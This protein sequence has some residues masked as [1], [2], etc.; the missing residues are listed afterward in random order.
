MIE[1]KRGICLWGGEDDTVHC[2]AGIDFSRAEFSSRRC[3]QPAAWQSDD[4]SHDGGTL[5][6]VQSVGGES[7]LVIE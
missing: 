1:G 5:Q 6:Q 3:N 7:E 4:D 2:R